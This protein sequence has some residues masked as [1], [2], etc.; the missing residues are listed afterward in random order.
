ME[1][2]LS[3]RPEQVRHYASQPAHCGC[4]WKNGSVCD[5]QQG[6]ELSVRSGHCRIRLS[7]VLPPGGCTA[8]PHCWEFATTQ[9][10]V[11]KSETGQTS[12]VNALLDKLEG[13]S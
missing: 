10:G 7:R 1:T 13:P 11:T 3:R 4:R 6:E 9:L 12:A 2:H 8:A 5:W